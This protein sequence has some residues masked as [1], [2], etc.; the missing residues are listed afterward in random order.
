MAE[1]FENDVQMIAE[2]EGIAP[3]GSEH[4]QQQQSIAT[5]P[6]LSENRDK[7]LAQL[8]AYVRCFAAL[9]VELAEIEQ[10]FGADPVTADDPLKT[11]TGEVSGFKAE[12]AEMRKML[13]DLRN[14]PA[15]QAQAMLQQ[16]QPQQPFYYQP[17]PQPQPQMVTTAPLPYIPTPNFT[18]LMP[19]MP[20]FNR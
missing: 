5:P 17:Q 19:A 15:V 16:Q 10:R 6:P 14:A 7:S 13:E 4:E 9:Q 12:M 20:N 11:L 8:D 1:E 3:A 18:P 2:D